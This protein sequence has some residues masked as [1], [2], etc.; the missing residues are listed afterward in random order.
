MNATVTLSLVVLIR[1]EIGNV[2]QA[3]RKSMSFS[4]R[5]LSIFIQAFSQVEASRRGVGSHGRIELM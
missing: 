1:G 2:I 4:L 3:F 5:I